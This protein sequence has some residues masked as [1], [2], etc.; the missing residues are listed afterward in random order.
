[1]L[2]TKFRPALHNQELRSAPW[3]RSFAA[4]LRQAEFSLFI[5]ITKTIAPR[6]GELRTIY[7]QLR[8]HCDG[9]T[10]SGVQSSAT[11]RL[12][13]FRRTKAH[14]HTHAK[15]NSQ[16]HRA[17]PRARLSQVSR[18]T[19]LLCFAGSTLSLGDRKLPPYSLTKAASGDPHLQRRSLFFHSPFSGATKIS[20]ETTEAH[21][22]TK[23]T[24]DDGSLKNEERESWRS[25]KQDQTK[26]AN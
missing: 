10:K 2:N 19:L 18:G 26:R 11:P 20:S 25:E 13:Q 17:F 23:S 8:D 9:H 21:P 6:P 3:L 14:T 12:R 5:Y 4:N 24:R 15:K 22:Y 16:L 7:Y 1:M